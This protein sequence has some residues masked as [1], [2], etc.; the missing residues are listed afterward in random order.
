M[1]KNDRSF[2]TLDGLRGIAA[3]AVIARHAPAYF[4][5]VSLYVRSPDVGAP[6]ISLGPFFESYLAVDFFF[7]LSGFILAHAYGQRLQQ[8][9]SAMQFMTIRLI[10]LYPLYLLGLSIAAIVG[11]VEVVQGQ[12]NLLDFTKNLLAAIL[13]LPSPSLGGFDKLFPLNAPAWSLFFELLANLW[14]GYIGGRLKSTS[15][16]VIVAAAGVA[17][18]IAVV[19]RL[20]GFGAAGI[21]A[22][23]DGFEWRSIGAG[24]LRVTYSFSAGV[25]VYKVWNVRKPTIN[26]PHFALAL[27]LIAILMQHPPEYYQSAFDLLVTTVIFPLLVWLG[28]SSVA[29]G[30]VARTFTWLGTSSYAVYVLHVPLYNLTLKIINEI[31]PGDVDD[32]RFYWGVIFVVF[33]FAVAILVDRFFDRPIRAMLTAR[34]GTSAV[35]PVASRTAEL[36]SAQ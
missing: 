35:L 5:S 28:A 12:A 31:S 27:L 20:F 19:E 26:V 1:L 22:M 16:C 14:L 18:V 9:L 3:L 8:G 17:L 29:S 36:Q 6:P 2:T 23:V 24:L 25:L 15:L 13:F 34:F 11:W 32:F 21:G 33:I 10:R 4:A 30:I 7:V